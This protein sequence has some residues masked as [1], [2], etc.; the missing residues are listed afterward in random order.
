MLQKERGGAHMPTSAVWSFTDPEEFTAHVRGTRMELA[1]TRP[2]RFAAKAVRIDLHRMWL[3]RVSESLPRAAHFQNFPGRA[4]IVFRTQ[5]GPDTIRNGKAE[6]LT[7]LVLHPESDESFQ[8]TTGATHLGSLSLPIED[9][10]VVG[11]N[12][13][14]GDFTPPKELLFIAARPAAFT[15]L[16]ELHAA[17]GLL[18]ENAPEIIAHPESARGLEQALIAAMANCLGATDEGSSQILNSRHAGVMRRFYAILEANSEQVMHA[19]E[20]CKALGVSNRTLTTCCQEAVGMTPH[21]YLR[22]R[23]LHLAHRALAMSEP[24]VTTVTQIATKYGFWDLGRFAV[25]YRKLFG[26]R[27]S[28]TL[29]RPAAGPQPIK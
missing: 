9:M 24:A 26:E 2:G 12:F 6:P 20:M 18:A 25:V 21:H 27:P 28:A 16:L 23:Q 10:A 19:P 4:F 14:A 22:L 8:R 11:Q 13:G 1:I 17:A 5:A 7:G 3:Q 29:A 15:R